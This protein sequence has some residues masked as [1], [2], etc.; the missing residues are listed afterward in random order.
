[1]VGILILTMAHTRIGQF[2]ATHPKSFQSKIVYNHI[3]YIITSWKYVYGSIYSGPKNQAFDYG[4]VQ[5][6][7]S[8]TI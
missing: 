4:M 3:S 7:H 2:T 5:S 1:M 6:S 8:P